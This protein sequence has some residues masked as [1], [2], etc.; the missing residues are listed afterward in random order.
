MGLELAQRN[1]RLGWL[2]FALSCLIFA[3]TFVLAAIYISQH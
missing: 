3:G 2:L 1:A